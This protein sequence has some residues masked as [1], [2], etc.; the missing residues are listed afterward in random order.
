[1]ARPAS[2]SL[3]GKSR[4]FFG[5]AAALTLGLAGVFISDTL[6]LFYLFWEASLLAVYFWIGIHGK[7]APGTGSVYSVLMRF[8]LLTLAGSLPMLLGMGVVM[9]SGQRDPGI[10]GLAAVVSGLSPSAQGWVFFA[11]LLG[12]AVKLPFL[13]LHGWLRDTYAVAPAACRA[14]LSAAMSKMGAYGLILVLAPAFADQ[15]EKYS[16]AL[17]LWCVAAVLYGALICLAQAR[18]VDLLA[19]S[20]LSH[21][22]LLALGVFAGV[23]GGDAATAGMTGAVFQAFNHGLIM[24]V[25]FVLDSRALK[26]GESPTLG[27]LSGLRVSHRRLAA[28]MLTAI[29]ASASLPGFSNFVGEILVYFAAFQ[30]SPW[31]VLLAGAGAL[32]GAA[33]LVRAFHGIFFGKPSVLPTS[34]V[35]F[36]PDLARWEAAAALALILLWVVLGL[37]PMPFLGPVEKSLLMLNPRGWTG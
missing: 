34:V 16:A 18:L 6:L 31:L 15:I 22:G 37:Y 26:G 20:S 9:A 25:L 29:F 19:Y 7:T 35:S 5:S 11:F 21:L 1:M 14:L 4:S 2:G 12:F 13:G 36:A 3:S 32:I 8:V 24:A 17:Q 30:S 10:S 33:A 23:R 28:L 27:V